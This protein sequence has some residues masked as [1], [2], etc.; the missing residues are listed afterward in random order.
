MIDNRYRETNIDSVKQANEESGMSYNEVKEYIA[1]TTGGHN[2]SKFSNTDIDQIRE[3][4]SN[5]TK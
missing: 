3:K 5:S 2:T 1:K 4:L